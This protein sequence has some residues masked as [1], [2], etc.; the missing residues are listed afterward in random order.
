M[1]DKRTAH[2]AVT[3]LVV[4]SVVVLVLAGKSHG[5]TSKPGQ[6]DI[7]AGLAIH[8]EHCLRCHGDTGRG[9]GRAARLF[10]VKPADWTN[11]EHMSKVTDQDMVKII[12][13]GGESVGKAKVMPA[14]KGRLSDSQIRDVIAFVRSLSYKKIK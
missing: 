14:F 9:D 3:A 12:S 1:K 4:F 8:K 6:D 13:G 5:R 7:Q 11:R 10:S 2:I